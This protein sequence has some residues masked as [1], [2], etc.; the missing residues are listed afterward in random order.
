MQKT[1]ISLCFTIT[2]LMSSCTYITQGLMIDAQRNAETSADDFFGDSA[3][4]IVYLEQN[5]D[6]YDSLWFYYTTQGSDFM[7]YTTFVNLEQATNKSLF[8]NS[9]N[10]RKLRF[11]TQRPSF[12]NP[13]GLPVGLVKDTYQ[14]KDYIGF[15][16][17]AC[18]TTQLNY[19]GIGI[20]VDGAP[21]LADIENLFI[22]VATALEATLADQEKFARL[23]EAVIA[24]GETENQAEFRIELEKVLA[25]RQRYNLENAPVHPQQNNIN[26]AYGYGRLDAFGRIY[27][28]IFDHLV[29]AGV[30]NYNPANAPVSYPF[31]WDT[32]HSDFVQW[33]GV[34]DNNPGGPLGFLGPL[35]RNTGEV[36]G[37]FATFDLE[38]KGDIGY[39]SSV[40]TRNLNRLER[41]LTDLQS[42]LWP[43]HILPPINQQLAAAGKKLFSQYQC[44]AC[45]TSIDR[46][47]SKRLMVAQHS[48]LKLIGT[49]PTMAMN[50]LQRTG[51]S[52]YFEGLEIPKQTPKENFAAITPALP[53]L[54][55]ATAQ[56]ILEPDHDKLF[57]RRWI[58]QLA[59]LTTAF[60]DNPI[61]ETHR[62]VDFEIVPDDA[63][64]AAKIASLAVYRGRSLNGIWATAPYLHNGSVV[65]LYELLLPRCTDAE[66]AA[67]KKCRSN[68][69][70]V[71]SREFD[72]VKVGLTSKDKTQYPELYEFNTN[73]PSNSNGGHEYAAG[74]TP[75]IKRDANGKPIRDKDGNYEL[76]WFTAMRENQR[77]ALVE[78]LKTL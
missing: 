52:G 75:I 6:R 76:Q 58:E 50:A 54:Q 24:A 39:V 12:D 17:A 1:I 37:V 61:K 63:S 38:K 73:L 19:Q 77:M 27:N 68:H 64:K 42:P 29:P 22:N 30:D 48:S 72:P 36:L 65:N 56:V 21:A 20:R 67:G 33:N 45:H 31:L 43:E 16:C 40:V 13:D 78:Y 4:Q 10:M 7:P 57:L 59:D 35:G 3:K 9:E 66:I 34:G 41:Q 23:A 49:D 44:D 28:R 55:N 26:V 25:E 53:A 47:D 8:R 60:F 51:K 74:N 70:T 71:G 14:G 15:T 2:L 46:S 11:L 32:P 62:H 5:W 69:F 18:H